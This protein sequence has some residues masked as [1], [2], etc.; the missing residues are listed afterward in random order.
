MITFNM[1]SSPVLPKILSNAAVLASGPSYHGVPPPKED[2]AKL[3]ANEMNYGAHPEV[4]KAAEAATKSYHVY[5]DPAQSVLRSKIAQTH[6]GFSKDNVVAGSGSDDCLDVILRV[7][8]PK[9]AI[10]PTPTF[11]MYAALCRL[12]HVKTTEIPRTEGT[13]YIDV[14][15]IR[16]QADET[17]IIF[18]ANPNNPTGTMTS[19]SDVETLAQTG[20]LVVLDEAYMEFVEALNGAPSPSLSLVQKYANVV[21]M[22]TLS[23]WAGLA[24]LR[25]GYAL[26]HPT[27]IKAMMIAKQ[28]YNIN[29]VAEA[30]AI[31]ALEMKAELTRTGSNVHTVAAAA[32]ELVGTLRDRYKWISPI[33]TDANFVLCRVHGFAASSVASELAKQNVMI[34]FFGTQ[35]GALERYIRISVGRPQDMERLHAALARV[36]ETAEVVAS[37]PS[38]PKV[39]LF[40]MDGVLAEVSQSYRAAIKETAASFGVTVTDAD[41]NECKSKGDANNDWVLTHRLILEKDPKNKTGYDAV[42]EKFQELYLGG[43]RDKESLIPEKALLEKITSQIPSAIVTGRP[44]KEAEYFL[45]LHGLSSCFQTIVCMEDTPRPKPDPGPVLKALKNLGAS[46]SLTDVY[47]LGDTVDDIRAARAAGVTGVGVQLPNGTDKSARE[48]ISLAGAD[49]VMSPGLAELQAWVVASD[50]TGCVAEEIALRRCSKEQVLTKEVTLWRASE[51]PTINGIVNGIV[52]D[53]IANGEAALIKY[54]VRFGDMPSADAPYIIGKEEME[55]AFNR[56]SSEHQALLQRSAD[57]VR[58]F[59]E[60]QKSALQP[61]EMPIL[62]GNAGH[63]VRAVKAAGCYAPGGRYPLPSSVLM[64]AI[65]ARVAGCETVCVASPRPTDE[66]LAAAHVAGADICLKIGGA[67]A[68]AAMAYGVGEVPECD[69]IVGPGNAFVTAAKKMVFGKVGIDML[70]G[71]SEVLVLADETANARIVAADLIAQSEHDTAASSVLISTSEKL[72]VDVEAELKEQLS[73]LPTAAVAREALKRNGMCVVVDN[74]EDGI[75]CCNAL[76]P[77]HLEVHTAEPKAV[78]A[79]LDSYGAIFIGENCAEVT[80]D[81]ASG[82]NH[83]LPTSGTARFSGGLSV[84]TF[85][86]V[87]T[88][89]MFDSDASARPLLEDAEKFALIE[90]LHGHAN[91]AKVRLNRP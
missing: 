30:A 6:P 70:A 25:V 20:A 53:V 4:L 37:E 84:L 65:P 39:L 16:K 36:P 2:V 21:V 77:E 29:C 69:I 82:P 41:I 19:L 72:I 63:N 71:P 76:A 18:L 75:Q 74:L 87:R 78:A 43:L 7:I 85:L 23:K 1:A 11:G 10:I 62:G 42:V 66:T 91:A 47:M 64:T 49:M 86:C 8:A 88:F 52:T 13:F 17:S 5:P 79:R 60:K 15:A 33:E 44:R 32:K 56:I 81:Y 57:R 24:G 89:M 26:A 50:E 51:N 90:G 14:E 38:V 67:Q 35:G 48:L 9:R 12:H 83:T 34:R 59:A 27:I 55:K 40:D 45:N 80:G 73:T 61:F 46:P 3:N 28:P 54:A 58:L 68:I 31:K 22:R